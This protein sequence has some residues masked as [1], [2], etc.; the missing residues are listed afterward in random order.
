[1][2]KELSRDRG[3]AEEIGRH[4]GIE[5][6]FWV[7]QTAGLSDT[8]L[9][10]MIDSSLELLRT[11]DQNCHELSAVCKL[12]QLLSRLDLSPDGWLHNNPTDPATG[13]TGS[14]NSV[15]SA[16]A[17]AGSRLEAVR[18][19]TRLCKEDGANLQVSAILK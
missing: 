14:P 6:L 17:A 10:R 9:A 11:V 7:R 3:G 1:M 13:G 5:Q 16:V 18:A 12:N 19:I 2:L 15:P 4:G 8:T